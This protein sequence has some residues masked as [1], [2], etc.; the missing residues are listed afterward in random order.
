MWAKSDRNNFQNCWE[1][2][3]GNIVIYRSERY[4]SYQKDHATLSFYHLQLTSDP[5]KSKA[6]LRVS[7]AVLYTLAGYLD[8]V[9]MNLIFTNNSVLLQMLCLLLDNSS[10]QLLAAEC[11][12]TIVGRKVNYNQDS[13]R[14]F[15]LFFQVLYYYQWFVFDFKKGLWLSNSEK[16]AK[17]WSFE[18]KS[19]ITVDLHVHSGK[20]YSKFIDMFWFHILHIIVHV[21]FRFSVIFS[22]SL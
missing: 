14:F 17:V 6:H 7:E 15:H 13:G 20:L 22:F 9:S 5:Q 12:L 2:C 18:K 4:L 21:L 19:S 8:W 11:L 10:L 3:K 1:I 16:S